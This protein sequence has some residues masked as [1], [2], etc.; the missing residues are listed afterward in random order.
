LFGGGR[1]LQSLL[2]EVDVRAFVD[3]GTSRPAERTKGEEDEE[4]GAKQQKRGPFVL[5]LVIVVLLA[6]GSLLV[7]RKVSKRRAATAIKGVQPVP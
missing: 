6:M 3:F 5:L 7:I 2:Q 1:Q 4:N